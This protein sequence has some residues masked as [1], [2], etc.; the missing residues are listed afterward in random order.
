MGLFVIAARVTL[1][2]RGSDQELEPRKE[3]TMKA[4]LSGCLKFGWNLAWSQAELSG[5]ERDMSEEKKL[6]VSSYGLMRTFKVSGKLGGTTY[7][8]YSLPTHLPL[9]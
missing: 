8:L 3:V 6:F 4:D 2:H 9:P 5:W 1:T 7:S